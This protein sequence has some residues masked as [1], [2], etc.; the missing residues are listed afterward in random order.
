MNNW[1]VKLGGQPFSDKDTKKI[2][3]YLSELIDSDASSVQTFNVRGVS[4]ISNYV[5]VSL[6]GKRYQH[7][8]DDQ[9]VGYSGLLAGTTTRDIDLRDAKNI[10]E[11]LG[12][13]D[14]IYDIATGHFS[15]FKATNSH[16]ECIVDALPGYK[17]FYHQ[18]Q[19]GT[20]YVSNLPGLI[21]LFKPNRPNISFFINYICADGTYGNQT[22]DGDIFVLPAFGKLTWSKNNGLCIGVYHKISDLIDGKSNIKELIQ[23]TSDEYK[24]VARYI[25]KYH[26]AA[27]SQSGGYDSRIAISMFQGL[28]PDRIMCYTFPDHPNDRNLA[29]K[30]VKYYGFDHQFISPTDIP[31]VDKLDNF[32]N[33]E[34]PFFIDYNNVFTY[35]LHDG[36]T[37]VYKDQKQ[38]QFIGL[39]GESY[40]NFTKF[41]CIVDDNI[42]INEP[43]FEDLNLANGLISSEAPLSSLRKIDLLAKKTVDPGFLSKDGYQAIRNKLFLHYYNSYND[44]LDQKSIKDYQIANIH[45]LF[46]RLGNYQ[47]YKNYFFTR[48]RDFFLP[49]GN[50][51]FLQAVLNSP[52]EYLYRSK[53]NSL[54]HQLSKLLT[55][56]DSPKYNFTRGLHWDATKVQKYKYHRID[57]KFDS[58]AK[59]IFGTKEKFTTNIRKKFFYDN[60][61][62]FEDVVNTHSNSELWNYLDKQKVKSLF[63][64]PENLYKNHSDIITK[65]VPLLKKGI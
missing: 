65:V 4:Y 46:E 34:S 36:I 22:D 20:V 11:N 60:L 30:L 62:H 10:K 29:K 56:G 16:F 27:I 38:V 8:D 64:S 23:K 47:A 57:K 41:K 58:I 43:S 33:K 12:D 35:L 3:D 18:Q 48:E 37:S 45:F 50:K 61:S 1:I 21:K 15:L 7:I 42:T 19:D 49:F 25:V 14:N 9:L 5:D 55:N 39:G 13:I 2:K 40:E 32:L 53:K 54:H 44:I 28:D 51:I 6:T 17:I 52:E 59:K 26:K 63:N 31:S 24:N